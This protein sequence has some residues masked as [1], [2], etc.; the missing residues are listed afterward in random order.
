MSSSRLH[1][2]PAA[3]AIATSAAVS[4]AAALGVGAQRA[5]VDR[6]TIAERR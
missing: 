2:D 1:I 6:G 3:R 4:G 5:A